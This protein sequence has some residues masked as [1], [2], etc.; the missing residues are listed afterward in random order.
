[1]KKKIVFSGDVGNTNQPIINDPQPVQQADYVVLEST[2]G[3]RTHGERP[4]SI[5]ALTQVLQR[6]LGRGGTVVIPSF[7]VGRTQEMLYFIRE[8]KEKGLV[9]GLD[10]FPVYVDSPLA[11][12]ATSIFLQCPTSDLDPEARAL[13]ERG[14]NPLWFSG[15]TMSLSKEESQAINADKRPR[16]FC[17]PAACATRGASAT[18]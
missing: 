6:T 2:Y 13:V 11:N 10:G 16:L 5:G 8:I 9:K 3:T 1:M 12:E 4:D 15:L 18:I 17:P 14:I 7:A